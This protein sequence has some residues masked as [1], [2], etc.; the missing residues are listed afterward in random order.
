MDSLGVGGG[1]SG[2]SDATRWWVRAPVARPLVAAVDRVARGGRCCRC[3]GVGGATQ[4][5]RDMAPLCNR[6]LSIDSYVTRRWYTRDTSDG[7][8]IPLFIGNSR[9]KT[10]GMPAI[11]SCG[12]TIL[13]CGSALWIEWLPMVVVRDVSWITTSIMNNSNS[14]GQPSWFSAP[15]WPAWSSSPESNPGSPGSTDSLPPA[16]TSYLW[17]HL[18]RIQLLER[19]VRPLIGGPVGG[20]PLTQNLLGCHRP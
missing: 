8:D 18:T 11:L 12:W 19:Q 10:E 2:R 4:L 1:G 5:A 9:D 14:P 17:R 7:L 13:P 16:R 6:F 15:F 20:A 3:Y